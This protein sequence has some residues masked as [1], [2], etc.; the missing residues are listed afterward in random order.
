MYCQV[1]VNNENKVDINL[2][3]RLRNFGYFGYHRDPFI[4]T[5]Q[6]WKRVKL[7]D[8]KHVLTLCLCL[9]SF[10]ED[11]ENDADYTPPQSRSFEDMDRQERR[12]SARFGE[13]RLLARSL[14]HDHSLLPMVLM[15]DLAPG[16]YNCSACMID[17]LD[18]L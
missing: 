3:S 11:E 14:T 7:Y 13:N 10:S 16:Q 9:Q 15:H 4:K 12:R 17:Y 18:C 2:I 6:N 8:C 5:I 1:L